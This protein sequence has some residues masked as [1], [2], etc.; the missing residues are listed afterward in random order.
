[1]MESFQWTRVRHCRVVVVADGD[2]E[3]EPVCF[4]EWFAFSPLVANMRP[5][6]NFSSDTIIANPSR[7]PDAIGSI[8]GNWSL[9]MGHEGNAVLKTCLV[10]IELGIKP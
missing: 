5:H 10:F 8:Q 7:M 9:G 1:M 4:E 2:D 6:L 3:T